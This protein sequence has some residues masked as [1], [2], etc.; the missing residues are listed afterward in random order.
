MNRDVILVLALAII[1]LLCFPLLGLL[2][3]D[4]MPASV[5]NLFVPPRVYLLPLR[6]VFA[7]GQASPIT[8]TH[9]LLYEGGSDVFYVI[10]RQGGWV[11]LQTL[12]GTLNFWTA[13][14]NISTAPPSAAQYDFADRGKTIRLVP[15]TGFACLHEE[16]PPPIF[17][18]CQPA[19]NF[20][21]AKLIAKITANT[22]T[23]YLVEIEGKSY[24]VE[25]IEH[26]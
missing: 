15:Q 8:D 13:S 18:P 17:A 19:P 11:R 10:G 3:S 22:I 23:M 14:E 16:V 20:S 21:S 25:T 4:V 1:A 26:R 2:M 7:L 5:M 24:F 9:F 12:D 6:Q